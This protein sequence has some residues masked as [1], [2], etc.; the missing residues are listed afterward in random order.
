MTPKSSYPKGYDGCPYCSR[1]KSRRSKQCQACRANAQQQMAS[2]P[3]RVCSRCKG[4]PQPISNF[5]RRSNRRGGYSSECSKCCTER[6][7]RWHADNRERHIAYCKKWT[8][9]NRNSQIEIRRKWRY[10]RFGVT[11]TWYEETLAEQGRKCAICGSA[12]PV[13]PNGKF[14]I[15]HDHQCCPD[16]SA[17]DKCRR[18]LL[19]S[20]CNLKLGIIEDNEWMSKANR[21]LSR[22]TATPDAFTHAVPFHQIGIP[23]V[24]S[25]SINPT[26]IPVGLPLVVLDDGITSAAVG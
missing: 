3:F 5:P 7:R 15:D 23:R 22:Y 19:C 21:Y 14:A 8:E 25:K 12:D 11:T 26:A 16:K 2:A 20:R 17:C 1:L 18:G 6:S 9:E 4:E 24:V 10:R 13:N